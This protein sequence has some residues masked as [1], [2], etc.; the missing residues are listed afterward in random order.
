MPFQINIDASILET[1]SKY[2]YILGN[3]MVNAYLRGLDDLKDNRIDEEVFLAMFADGRSTNERFGVLKHRTITQMS[4]NDQAYAT[5]P[6][7]AGLAYS[8]WLSKWYIGMGRAKHIFDC[9]MDVIIHMKKLLNEDGVAHTEVFTQKY[10][11]AI[12]RSFCRC[13]LP[14]LRQHSDEAIA[15]YRKALP[16]NKIH[17]MEL[18]FEEYLMPKWRV[19]AVAWKDPGLLKT[20]DG[21]TIPARQVDVFVDSQDQFLTACFGREASGPQGDLAAQPVGRLLQRILEEAVGKCITQSMDNE[22]KFDIKRTYIEILGCEEMYSPMVCIGTYVHLENETFSPVQP[23]MAAL[24]GIAICHPNEDISA[25]LDKFA[26][27][28]EIRK[29]FDGTPD[30]WQRQLRYV[31][32]VRSDIWRCLKASGFIVKPSPRMFARNYDAGNGN[33]DEVLQSLYYPAECLEGLHLVAFFPHP[34]QKEDGGS[35]PKECIQTL[36]DINVDLANWKNKHLGFQ[37][38][39]IPV[40][41]EKNVNAPAPIR[42]EAVR[43]QDVEVQNAIFFDTGHRVKRVREADIFEEPIPEASLEVLEVQAPKRQ[44]VK[45]YSDVKPEEAVAEKVSSQI[46]VWGFL[47]MLILGIFTYRK[48]F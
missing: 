42:P 27:I 37:P 24:D 39:A 26:D 34:N 38:I 31:V 21:I 5:D 45:F 10:E 8:K 16:H 13:V 41:N 33:T 11:E 32:G 3:L 46:W 20:Q 9:L 2:P 23:S 30:E 44:K 43:P 1:A 12:I 19:K 14:D 17:C 6:R 28:Q 25:G 48:Q 29:S 4:A 36:N 7:G 15:W 40:P 47:L 18:C 35:V 22:A